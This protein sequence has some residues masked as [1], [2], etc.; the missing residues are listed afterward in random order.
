M[1]TI[2]STTTATVPALPKYNVVLETSEN[3]DWADLATLDLSKFDQPGGKEALARELSTAN[4]KIGMNHTATKER[5][6][7]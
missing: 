7:N 3:L 4:E 1:T 2:S 5:R 6:N